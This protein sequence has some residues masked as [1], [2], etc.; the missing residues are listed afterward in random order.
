MDQ[1][2]F[3][4]ETKPETLVLINNVLDFIRGNLANIEKVW[5]RDS[6]QF[7]SAST[8]MEQYLD[9]NLRKINVKRSDI[10][11]LMQK[12]SIDDTLER[13]NPTA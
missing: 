13:R 12:L 1:S 5:G 11:D 4:N 6:T 10:D 3:H 2:N 9:D 7:K 8:I